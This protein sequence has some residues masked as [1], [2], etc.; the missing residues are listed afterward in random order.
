[1][2][3]GQPGDQEDELAKAGGRDARG[4]ADEQRHDH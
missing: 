3:R 2:A 4:G 1:M